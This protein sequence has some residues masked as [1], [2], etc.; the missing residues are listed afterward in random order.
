MTRPDYTGPISIPP[1]KMEMYYHR[2]KDMAR[3]IQLRG[4]GIVTHKVN[5]GLL[6]D[7][8]E[9]LAEDE[10]WSL[11]GVPRLFTTEEISSTAIQPIEVETGKVMTMEQLLN[12][13]KGFGRVRGNAAPRP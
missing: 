9:Q 2:F 3:A 11:D 13:K 7:W 10:T 12:S 4:E 6:D 8:L 1:E 5:K